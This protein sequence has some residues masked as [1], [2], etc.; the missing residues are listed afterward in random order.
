MPDHRTREAAVAG[1]M[2]KSES[3]RDLVRREQERAAEAEVIRQALIE[4]ERSGAPRHF[5][6]AAFMRRKTKRYRG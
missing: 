4:G 5:D 2:T 1:D 6:S 3:I